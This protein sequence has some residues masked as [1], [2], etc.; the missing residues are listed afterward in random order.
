[1]QKLNIQ[2]AESIKQAPHYTSGY[3]IDGHKVQGADLVTAVI[4]P[5]GTQEGK[6]TVD[7]QILLKDE[8]GV[9]V[10]SAVALITGA[11]L[12]ELASVIKEVEKASPKGSGL[13]IVVRE[14][15]E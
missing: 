5:K 12:T 9:V 7:L 8:H 13:E 4:V 15:E 11:L 14:D 2:I 1:M 10:G 6:C 3:R